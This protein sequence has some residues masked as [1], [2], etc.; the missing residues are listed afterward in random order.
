MTAAARQVRPPAFVYRRASRGTSP[1]L[2]CEGASVERLAA[3]HGTPLYIYSAE[4][5]RTRLQAF[6]KAFRAIPHTI[7]YSVKAN[8]TLAILRLI[9]QQRGGFDVVSGGELERVLRTA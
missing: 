1:T 6:N 2:F 8:S 7:C 3:R 4:T 5:I 9:A